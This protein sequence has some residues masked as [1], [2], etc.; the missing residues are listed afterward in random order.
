VRVRCVLVIVALGCGKQ[1]GSLTVGAFA[2]GAKVDGTTI[3]LMGNYS[4]EP[5][6][7]T[8]CTYRVTGNDVQFAI[9]WSGP[10]SSGCA[11]G[12]GHESPMAITV[13]CHGP[14]LDRGHYLVTEG[15]ADAR[16][17]FLLEGDVDASGV[18]DLTRRLQE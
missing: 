12:P 15:L 17:S 3:E 11:P 13:R 18:G 14:R 4:G 16:G 5:I 2:N 1:H 8:S 7:E 9:T 10:T 6:T